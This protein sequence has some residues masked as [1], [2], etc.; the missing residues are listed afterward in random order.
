MTFKRTCECGKETGAMYFYKATA[1]GKFDI[2][3]EVKYDTDPEGHTY[4]PEPC[5]I[6]CPNYSNIVIKEE[7][8]PY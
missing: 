7:G 1:E 5:S 8:I 4:V 6:D 3:S 2:W